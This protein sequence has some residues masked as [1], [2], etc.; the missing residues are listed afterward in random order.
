MQIVWAYCMYVDMKLSGF[1]LCLVSAV[2][3]SGELSPQG[4]QGEVNSVVVV[5]YVF[6]FTAEVIDVDI[7]LSDNSYTYTADLDSQQ[8]EYRCVSSDS[9]VLTWKY[10]TSTFSNPLNAYTFYGVARSADTFTI[11]CYSGTNQLGEMQLTIKGMNTLHTLLPPSDPLLP[12][13]L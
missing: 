10:G 11:E 4:A 3:V 5:V 12:L 7:S 13:S 8:L 9:G 2:L 1:V 6:M